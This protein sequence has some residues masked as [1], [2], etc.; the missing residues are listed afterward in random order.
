MTETTDDKGREYSVRP[1]GN[2]TVLDDEM[3]ATT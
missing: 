3:F 1:W 2:Y